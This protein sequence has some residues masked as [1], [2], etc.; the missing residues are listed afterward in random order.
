[1]STERSANGEFRHS[2][3]WRI[4]TAGAGMVA[5]FMLSVI[6]VRGLD[7]RDAAT[8][9]AILAALAVGPLVGRFGLGANVIRLVPAEPDRAARREIAGTHLLAV[10]IGSLL[11][12]PLIAVFGCNALIGH[13]G[14]VPVFLLASLL[15]AVE[16]ARLM[17]S[18]IF[19][20]TGRV[21]S[22]VATTHYVRT[23]LALP[24]IALTVQLLGHESLI[25]VLAT[26]LVVALAQFAVA[27]YRA[28]T[29]ISLPRLGAAVSMLRVAVSQGVRVFSV[30]LSEFMIMQGTIWLATALLTPAVATQYALAV[31]LGM[32]VA[33]FK[34]LAA[35]A[36]APPAARLWAAG[37]KTQVI[38]VLSNA[39]TLSAVVAVVLVVLIALFGRAAI[40]FAYGPDMRPTATMLLI[41]ALGGTVQ[42]SFNASATLLIIS[43]HIAEAARVALAVLAAAIPLAVVAALLLGPVALATV[44]AASLSVM[45]LS[46]YANAKRCLG[47]APR[48]TRHVTDA[49]R[50]LLRDRS[51]GEAEPVGA[52][53]G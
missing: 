33:L 25:S 12:A 27:L 2:F 26:Y 20:A 8:F 13:S 46:Q 48:A 17:V 36:V 9:F 15:I 6:V 51:A 24:F 42:A 49:A 23:V 50:E 30:D 32:Q 7:D 4:V 38:R 43:G 34:N 35:S 16:S 41:I 52:R 28:R 31:T 22:S 44:T 5:S 18:D 40:G 45:Y 1:V 39:A 37:A 11:S 19:A 29:E 53:R 3:L 21:K 14:F 47:A 10:G